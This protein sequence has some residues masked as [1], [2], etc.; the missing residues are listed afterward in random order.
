[1]Q[2][3]HSTQLDSM[4][5]NPPLLS[6]MP[7]HPEAEPMLADKVEAV[8]QA[9]K[10]AAMTSGRAVDSAALIIKSATL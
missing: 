1:M 7:Y 9:N 5:N 3:N 8:R 4:P 2:G 10:S 6:H